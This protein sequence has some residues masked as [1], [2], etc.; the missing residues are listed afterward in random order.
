MNFIRDNIIPALV[1]SILS[2]IALFAAEIYTDFL[3][4]FIPALKTI[5]PETY[6][7][8]IL[9]L[10]LLL[11]LVA[12]TATAIYLK[13]RPYRP[14][15]LSGKKFGFRWSAEIDYSNKRSEADIE[16]QWLCPKHK[17]YL[18]IKSAKIPETMYSTLWCMNCD[19]LYEIKSLGDV[20]HL[21]QAEAIVRREI[22]ERLRFE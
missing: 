3:P 21:E 20:V 5:A 12:M 1:G 13:A 4:A 10:V 15:A 22:L 7:K 8:I 18:G 9:F 16:L 2:G 6:V 11:V 19:K 17:V 14:R